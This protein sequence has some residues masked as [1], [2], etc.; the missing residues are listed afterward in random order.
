M[1]GKLDFRLSLERYQ[2]SC[3]GIVLNEIDGTVT[4][5]AATHKE[6]TPISFPLQ[7]AYGMDLTG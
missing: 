5:R 4:K 6:E 3:P 1:K 2:L 7:S